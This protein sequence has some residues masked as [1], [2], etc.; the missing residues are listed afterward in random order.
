M[1]S[2]HSDNCFRALI[3][4]VA[5]EIGHCPAPNDRAIRRL[6]AGVKATRP[7]DA[8]LLRAQQADALHALEMLAVYD[9][10]DRM[11]E[12]KEPH[13]RERE[14]LWTEWMAVARVLVE[15]AQPGDE[16]PTHDISN[17]W[18]VFDE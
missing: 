2:L 17:F 15:S 16:R 6:D 1:P 7:I 8:A 3:R 12:L 18:D 13:S 9:P 11:S 10:E 14:P 4:T 5:D